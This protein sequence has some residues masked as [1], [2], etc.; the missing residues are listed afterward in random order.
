M[1]TEVQVYAER[2]VDAFYEGYNC[3]Q[4]VVKAF[5][6]HPKMKELGLSEERFLALASSFGGGM[7]RLREVCGAVSAMFMIDGLLEGYGTPET[8]DVKKAHYA[9]VQ[10]LAKAFKEQHGTIICRELLGLPEGASAVAAM[11]NSSTGGTLLVGVEDDGAICGVEGEYGLADRGKPN[12]DG[13]QLRLAN[14]LRTRLSPPNAI[15]RYAIERRR[16]GEHD[17]C[18]VRVRPS[19]EPVYV[20]KRLY[21]RTFN[22]TVEMVGPDLVDFVA[23]RFARAAR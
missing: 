11:L 1:D 22:Q 18:L 4:S 10:D 21:V 2:A 12:W 13:W 23:R 20:D 3:A 14:V 7:G 9:R 5:A 8:G 16:A 17:V 19:D 6:D 15:L